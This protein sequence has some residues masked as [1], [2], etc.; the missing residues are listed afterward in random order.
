[1]CVN[2]HCPVPSLY[3]WKREKT[4][5]KKYLEI[6][7]P[8][9]QEKYWLGLHV[10]V[11]LRVCV[12]VNSACI[13]IGLLKCFQ[14]C[15]IYSVMYVYKDVMRMKAR[16]ALQCNWSHAISI[17]I[18]WCFDR[19]FPGLE[20]IAQASMAEQRLI[21]GVIVSTFVA[22]ELWSPATPPGFWNV[23]LG[24]FS[25]GHHACKVTALLTELSLQPC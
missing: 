19:V 11:Y 10:C 2:L 7:L 8:Y 24:P 6:S 14:V 15:S 9:S 22:L 25:S 21:K 12:L 3:T 23:V 1:M 17:L 5:A 20:L 18:F 13:Y 4:I 16:G